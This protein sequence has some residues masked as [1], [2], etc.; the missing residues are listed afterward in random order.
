[1]TRTENE[2]LAVVENDIGHLRNDVTDLK[3]MVTEMHNAFIEDKGARKAKGAIFWG[4]VGF[5]AYIGSNIHA[6]LNFFKG[7]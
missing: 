3:A 7:A 6:I 2:R 1:M 5:V 4:S